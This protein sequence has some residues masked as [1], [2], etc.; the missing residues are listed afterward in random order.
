MQLTK[1][2]FAFQ[3]CEI[4]ELRRHVARGVGRVLRFFFIYFFFRGFYIIITDGL[5][6][7]QFMSL[8]LKELLM[9]IINIFADLGV[10]S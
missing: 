8:Y 2:H 4:G 9:Q 10:P 7:R 1:E 6:S 5:A 3:L